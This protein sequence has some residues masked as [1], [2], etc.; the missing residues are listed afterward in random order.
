MINI[1]TASPEDYIF[2]QQIAY[3]TW[4][5]T[6]GRILEKTQLDYMLELFYS[7]DALTKSVA[8]T[9]HQL[10]LAR[11]GNA[12]LGFI[13]FENNYKEKPVTRI[14]KIYVLPETQ[15]QGIGKLL[16]DRV[17]AIAKNNR[18][19]VLSLNVNRQN[20][21]RNLDSKLGFEIVGEEDVP[22]E[23][24]YFMEDYIMEKIL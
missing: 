8:E 7:I 19:T 10:L 5:D 9:G 16:L 6:Y 12:Y 4:P 1:T 21:A 15:G 2:I 3:K 14:H 22:L 20:I 18:S 17:T 13:S 11:E 23:H 24:G